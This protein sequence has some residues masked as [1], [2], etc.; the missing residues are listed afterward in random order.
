MGFNFRRYRRRRTDINASDAIA[1][2][3]AVLGSGVVISIVPVPPVDMKPVTVR[4][5]VGSGGFTEAY[6][7]LI[8]KSRYRFRAER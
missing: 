2:R 3:A 6:A 7:S 5:A 1:H 4:R 8:K